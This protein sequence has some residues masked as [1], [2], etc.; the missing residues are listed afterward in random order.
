[1]HCMDDTDT[2]YA[3]N[4][5]FSHELQTCDWPRNVGCVPGQI[6]APVIRTS[7]AEAKPREPFVP[8][9]PLTFFPN[10]GANKKYVCLIGF[11]VFMHFV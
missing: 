5:V 6:G 7:S 1:M 4:F 11:G 10:A 3:F 9:P 8:R 2:D